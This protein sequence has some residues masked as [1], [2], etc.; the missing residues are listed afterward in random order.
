MSSSRG[1]WRVRSLTEDDW[2]DFVSV[3]GHAFGMTAPQELL[4]A[5]KQLHEPGRGIGAYDD[6]DR[7]VGIATAFSFDLTVPGSTLGAAGVS[8]VGVLPTHRRRGVLSSLMDYQ[9]RSVHDAGREPLAVLWASEPAI[10][11]RYGYGLASRAVSATVPR[12]A[13]SLLPLAPEDKELRLR[14]VPSDDASLTAPVYDR[15]A[16][17]RP[18]MMARDERWW[19]RVVDDQ[20][21]M[22]EGRSELRCVL[23]EDAEGVRGYARYQTKQDWDDF[24]KGRV[25]VREVMASDPAALAALYRYLFDLDLMGTTVL[26]NLPVDD[27]LLLWLRN[28]RL[29]KPELEDALYVRLVDLPA[30]LSSRT[31]ASEVDVV[32]E[33]RDSTCPW[34]AGRWRLTGGALG[35]SCEQTEDA[36]DLALD[37]RELGAAYLGGTSLTELAAAGLVTGSA[38][39]VASTSAAFAHTPAPWCPI[40][41]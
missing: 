17:T 31:Y 24:G 35:S 4:E 11:G 1:V 26:G 34:N 37:T 20:P 28:P 6:D 29:A 3:D 7:L 14:L 16:A 30:A 12:D 10:Y 38:A 22:R 23:A 18:G 27:P 2:D 33:V 41:F 19:R 13:V 9:L 25:S 15:V 40:V 5:S 8:W 32:L 36:P 39:T 21:S